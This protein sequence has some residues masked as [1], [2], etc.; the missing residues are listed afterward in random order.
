MTLLE[1]GKNL[2]DEEARVLKEAEE[3]RRLREE[4]IRSQILGVVNQFIADVGKHPSLA[5][6]SRRVENGTAIDFFV[7]SVWAAT[8]VIRL[9]VHGGYEWS[10]ALE[11]RNIWSPY[12]KDQFARRLAAYIREYELKH[13]FETYNA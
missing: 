7:E 5:A 3:K 4:I 8:V 12:N 13:P 10:L 11:D 1:H 6:Q 9:N 2:L